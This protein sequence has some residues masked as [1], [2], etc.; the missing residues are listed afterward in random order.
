MGLYSQPLFAKPANIMFLP[1]KID[2]STLNI[3]RYTYYIEENIIPDIQI[4]TGDFM[5]KMI[6]ENEYGIKIYGYL[7]KDHIQAW[8]LLLTD[9]LEQNPRQ[10]SIEFHF[11]CGEEGKAFYFKAER[12]KDEIVFSTMVGTENDGAY[13]DVSFEDNDGN[14]YHIYELADMN[15]ENAFKG[16]LKNGDDEDDENAVFVNYKFNEKTYKIVYSIKDIVFNPYVSP[17]SY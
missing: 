9:I 2:S 6:D 10:K 7:L 13:H 15:R 5:Q 4:S 11:Y 12:K 16:L 3:D 17:Y 1:K 8:K 14:E